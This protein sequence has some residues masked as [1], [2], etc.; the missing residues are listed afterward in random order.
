[1]G[2]SASVT[3]VEAEVLAE[4]NEANRE[5][6]I[7]NAEDDDADDGKEDEADEE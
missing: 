2:A 7:D 3:A 4:E 6:D 1:M 5:D